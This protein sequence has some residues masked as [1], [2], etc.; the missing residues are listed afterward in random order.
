MPAPPHS[1]MGIVDEPS[2]RPSPCVE[3]SDVLP[4][5]AGGTATGGSRLDSRRLLRLGCKLS[6]GLL[7]PCKN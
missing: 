4:Y 2:R 1:L 5:F 3:V 7:R 6:S